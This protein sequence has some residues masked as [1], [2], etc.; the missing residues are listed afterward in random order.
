M[1]TFSEKILKRMESGDDLKTYRFKSNGLFY[2]T[3]RFYIEEIESPNRFSEIL[4]SPQRVYVVIFEEALDPLK[5][6]L[7]I[8]I[9]PIEQKRVGHWNYALVSNH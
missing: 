3:K 5:K 4:H 7:K 2:Y 1:K 9:N 6:E 8:E